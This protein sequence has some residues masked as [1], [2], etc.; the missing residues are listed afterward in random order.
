MAA[1]N[2]FI[3]NKFI[4]FVNNHVIKCVK[5]KK[6]NSRFILLSAVTI[7]TFGNFV[8]AYNIN[9]NTKIPEE[10]KKYMVFYKIVNCLVSVATML[11]LGCL[12]TSDPVQK[13]L[14]KRLLKN[15]AHNKQL[16]NICAEGLRNFTA[17][18]G[19]TIFVKRLLVPF[20]STPIT[21]N[22]KKKISDKM[23]DEPANPFSQDLDICPFNIRKQ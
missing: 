12:L 8:D 1:T 7:D 5:D 14:R 19:T 6:I 2:T 16:F 20:I 23:P 3:N 18:A 22:I 4:P 10:E 21:S 17:L 9:K 13:E 11:S 15:I